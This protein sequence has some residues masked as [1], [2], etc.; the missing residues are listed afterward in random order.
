VRYRLKA[1]REKEFDVRIEVS[2]G[3]SE[4]LVMTLPSERWLDPVYLSV[5]PR[6][7]ILVPRIGAV[8][9][10]DQLGN[11]LAIEKGYRASSAHHYLGEVKVAVAD[12][13]LVIEAAVNDTKISRAADPWEAS[14][15]EVFVSP[16]GEGDIRQVFLLPE[17]MELAA[18]A[19]QGL[20]EGIPPIE[21]ARVTM[22]RKGIGYVL[23]A[24]IPLDAVAL[25]P[26]SERFYFEAAV[27]A[28]PRGGESYERN[29]LFGGPSAY[30]DASGY[31]RVLVRDR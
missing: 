24:T 28:R 31:A 12:E 13:F 22:A 15:V 2:G 11:R 7:S 26:D 5:R 21:N 27:S 17:T 3:F 18:E 16:D 20:V 19:R 8:E 23:R 9:S 30:K 10:P 25:S 14:C 4:F 29:T 1:G 6:P